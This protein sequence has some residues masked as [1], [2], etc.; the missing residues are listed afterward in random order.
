MDRFADEARFRPTVPFYLSSP[1]RTRESIARVFRG[2]HIPQRLAAFVHNEVDALLVLL[3]FELR[4]WSRAA[5]VGQPSL[6]E[7]FEQALKGGRQDSTLGPAFVAG[8]RFLCAPSQGSD[9][10]RSLTIS[11]RRIGSAYRRERVYLVWRISWKSPNDLRCSWTKPRFDEQP[12]EAGELRRA[13]RRD[14]QLSTGNSDRCVVRL[15]A[16]SFRRFR[17]ATSSVLTGSFLPTVIVRG[18]QSPTAESRW[19]Q[20]LVEATP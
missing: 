11:F 20:I 5:Q 1:D 19:I 17:D 7:S 6:M 18:G 4:L 14:V 9:R 8:L 12:D 16:L 13:L 10:E 15:P 2:S 3:S